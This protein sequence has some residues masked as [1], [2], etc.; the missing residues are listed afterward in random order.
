MGISVTGITKI[1]LL[2]LVSIKLD[3]TYTHD[4]T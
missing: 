2:P 3:T 1:K 4:L